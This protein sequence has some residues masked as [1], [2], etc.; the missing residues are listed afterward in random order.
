MKLFIICYSLLIFSINQT[1]AQSRCDKIC[2]SESDCLSGK[3]YLSEC[4]DFELCFQFCFS[5]EKS[6]KRC[7]ASGKT[8]LLKKLRK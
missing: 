4:K 3:C 2:T 7:Y 5:C 6:E 1:K 8:T